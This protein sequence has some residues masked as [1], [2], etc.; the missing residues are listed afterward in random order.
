[1]TLADYATFT[2]IAECRNLTLAA[3]RLHL[4][5]SAVSHAVA[6]MEASLGLSL[7][8]RT[9]KEWSLTES[10]RMLLPFAY[11]VL[12]EDNRFM[13]VVHEIHN[14]VS[15]AVTIGA[16]SSTCINWI[17]DILNSFR[18]QYPHIDVRVKGG[19]NNAQ[20]ISYLDN[21][22]IDLGIA[23]AEPTKD[24][25]VIELYEDEMLCVTSRSYVSKRPHVITAEEL[26]DL[27]L[28]LPTGD[29][30]AESLAVLKALNIPPRPSLTAIDDASL[31][32]MVSGGLGYCVVGKLVMKGIHLPVNI[33]SFD[34]P[35]YRYL[36][37]L[38]NKRIRLSPAGNALKKHMIAYI[39]NYPPYKL[40]GE[41]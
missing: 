25:G 40:P 13:E 17:P 32:S 33:Y 30:G 16:C 22:E 23:A 24:L 26:R 12:R 6:K 39:K 14:L 21:N 19:A 31:V 35:Q 3:E 34:P 29:F 37:L 36:G 7:F 15:G 9:Q 41:R 4:T 8:N 18:E 20:I 27:T 10:G 1:M 38:Y 28:L 5:K 11:S 2:A